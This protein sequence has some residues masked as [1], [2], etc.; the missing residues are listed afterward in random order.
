[1]V[2]IPRL[3]NGAL[4]L[5]EKLTIQRI[6]DPDSPTFDNKTQS[7][8]RTYNTSNAKSAS[9]LGHRAMLKLEQARKE[10]PELIKSVEEVT[11]EWVLD[12]LKNK[13]TNSR[14]DS[15]QIRSL[16]LLGKY[17]ALFK[18]YQQTEVI[19]D[20]QESLDDLDKEFRDLVKGSN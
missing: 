17:H 16:E 4:S 5:K 13:A 12:K 8:M 2:Y 11:P 7:A 3:K 20:K 6:I 19:D 15:D 10:N 1:L 9:V 18:D 14:K